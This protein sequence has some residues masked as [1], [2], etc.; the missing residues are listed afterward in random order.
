MEKNKETKKVVKKESKTELEQS[1]FLNSHEI[2]GFNPELF[3]KMNDAC[4]GFYLPLQVQIHWF[5]TS[6]PNGKLIV[7]EPQ[8]DPE[9]SPGKLTA[10]AY[11]YADRN[12]ENSLLC[13]SSSRK[14]I[15]EDLEFLDP[16]DACQA[17]ALSKALRFAGF[18]LPLTEDDLFVNQKQ[19]EIPVKEITEETK[20]IDTKGDLKQSITND[21]SNEDKAETPNDKKTPKKTRGRPS[22]KTT[23]K[24]DVKTV[25]NKDEQK[26]IN[27]KNQPLEEKKDEATTLI[28]NPDDKELMDSLNTMCSHPNHLN[29]T[30]KELIEENTPS[31][32]RMVRWMLDSPMA[33]EKHPK[34][35][36]AIKLIFSKLGIE[37]VKEIKKMISESNK[38]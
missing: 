8:V 27:E 14:G 35:V 1:Q 21:S 4:D 19:K 34:D 30:I 28:V 10:K 11:I 37:D 13:V 16:Y 26:K 3:K 20:P 23:E 25:E 12:D 32:I 18:S 7:D 22:K 9:R 17:S 24:K 6:Y 33:L 15:N 5:W 2:E 36:E 29:K 38:E 31:S